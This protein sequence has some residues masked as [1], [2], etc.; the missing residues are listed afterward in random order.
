MVLLYILLVIIIIGGAIYNSR[1]EHFACKNRYRRLRT[2]NNGKSKYKFLSTVKPTSNYKIYDKRSKMACRYIEQKLCG[3]HESRDC[4]VYRNDNILRCS[5]TIDM[6]ENSTCYCDEDCCSHKCI[7]N[8]CSNM[9][10]S[11]FDEYGYKPANR[12]RCRK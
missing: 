7:N 12:P 9:V 4:L 8:K 10:K 2:D 3:S 11:N 6:T 1:R 5:S